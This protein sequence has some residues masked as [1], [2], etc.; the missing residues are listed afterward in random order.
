[1]KPKT[2]WVKIPL[3]HPAEANAVPIVADATVA[4]ALLGEGRTIP[5]LILDTSDRP[6][7]E[8]MVEAQ[9][10]L[11]LTGDATSS[12][13]F[14]RRSGGLDTPL[15]VLEIKKPSKCLAVIAFDIETQGVLVDQILWAQG[16]YLQ[17]GRPGDR[18]VTTMNN[19]KILIEIPANRTFRRQFNRIYEKAL[20]R[21]FRK[22][23][24]SRSD[25]KT[26]VR[27]YLEEWRDA[28]H[29]RVDF[30]VH[31]ETPDSTST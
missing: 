10:R 5:L 18:L 30:E 9:S 21:T 31:R 20:Y 14:Q 2:R 29:R 11:D 22:A 6:D 13:S 23:G 7:I 16:V 25:A 12:W 15:L 3:R 17:P 26:S 27:S 1:M 4:T 8:T 28:L 19:P 24:M